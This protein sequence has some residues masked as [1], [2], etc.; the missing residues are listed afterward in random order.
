MK[1]IERITL[2]FYAAFAALCFILFVV[3]GSRDLSGG[4]YLGDHDGLNIY[5]DLRRDGTYRAQWP[6][7]GG[8]C[9]SARGSWTAGEQLLTF[10]PSEEKGRLAGRLG[11][12]SIMRNYWRTALVSTRGDHSFHYGPNGRTAFY[13][14]NRPWFLFP[15]MVGEKD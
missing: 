11:S 14:Q 3:P 2:L 12:L 10:F 13:R 8:S 9:G 5:L 7:C 6:G 15:R 1:S 4:Y